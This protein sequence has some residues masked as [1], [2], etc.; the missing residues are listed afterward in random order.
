VTTRRLTFI[1]GGARSGKSDYAQKLAE[2]RRR[3]VLFIATGQALDDEMS[4]RI[5]AHRQRRPPQW[6]TLELSTGVGKYMLEHSQPPGVVLLD[7]LTLLISNTMLQNADQV[8]PNAEVA[9]ADVKHE[10]ELLLDAIR[11]SQSDWIVVSNEVGQGIVPAYAAGRI[12]RDLLGWANKEMALQAEEVIW[13]VAGIPVPIGQHR[14]GDAA[15]GSG[16]AADRMG[17]DP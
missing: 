2:A 14:P 9:R 6:Q 5:A 3:P 13:M 15:S 17:G 4:G 10:I 7:C 1:L 11:R 12:F 16:Q 8:E